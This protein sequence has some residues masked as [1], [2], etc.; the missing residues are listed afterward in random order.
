MLKLPTWCLD[1][2]KIHEETVVDCSKSKDTAHRLQAELQLAHEKI[3]K[4]EAEKSSLELENAILSSMI[5]ESERNRKDGSAGGSML[6]YSV[7]TILT[8]SPCLSESGGSVGWSGFGDDINGEAVRGKERAPAS[9]TITVPV[10]SFTSANDNREAAKL[11]V[12]LKKIAQDFH[13]TKI[14]LD[15]EKEERRRLESKVVALESELERK[16]REVEE[17]ERDRSRADERC[18][19][20]L[21]IMKDSNAKARETEL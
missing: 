17:R 20:L 4:L 21:A 16:K 18:N 19:E 12:Q 5:E 1:E 8:L 3:K 7:I 6:I 11:R 9:S 14:A 13:S 2:R 10:A 15:K